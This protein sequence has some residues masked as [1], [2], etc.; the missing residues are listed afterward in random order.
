MNITIIPSNYV[1]LDTREKKREL[2]LVQYFLLYKR[3]TCESEVKTHPVQI[4][5]KPLMLLA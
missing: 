5:D 4:Y 1:L 2:F 3:R